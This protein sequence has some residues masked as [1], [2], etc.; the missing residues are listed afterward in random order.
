M[1]QQRN[2]IKNKGG[3]PKKEVKRDQLIGI[4]FTLYERRIIESKAKNVNLTVSEYLRE[5]A[6]KAKINY[7]NKALSKEILSFTGQLNHLAANLNQI[8]KKRNSNDE[9]NPVQRAE[10]KA[11]TQRIKDLATEIKSCLS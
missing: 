3:R 8:A 6:L 5:I 7:K 11:C 2:S 4:K 1:E 9:L 10:L